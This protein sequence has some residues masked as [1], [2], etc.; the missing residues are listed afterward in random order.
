M[1]VLHLI[2]S[3]FVGGPEKQ[4]LEHF[5]RFS[6]SASPR[7]VLASFREGRRPSEILEA[8]GRLG[9]AT[10]EL[11]SAFPLDPRA[12]VDLLRILQEDDVGL[13]CA[14][15]YKANVVGRLAS[16]VRRI[17]LVVFSRGWTGE[18]ARVR[19]YESVDR[20]FLRWADH[21]IAVSRA[22]G[23]ALLALGIP[24]ERI[25]TVPNCVEIPP[26]GPAAPGR[27]RRELGLGPNSALVV[28]AGRLSPEKSFSTLVQAARIVASQEPT[29]HFVVFGEGALR[30]GLEAEIAAAGLAGRFH[31]PGFRRGVAEILAEVDVFALTSLTEGLPNAVLEASAASRP[32][33]ATAVGGV[34]EVVVDGETGFLVPPLRPDLLADRILDLLR[35][36]DLAERMGRA[37]RERAG[38]RFSFEAQGEALQA[39]Y[40]RLG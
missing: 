38:R 39:I 24:E 25:S 11:R 15:G 7:L 28:S 8:A 19:F 35:D 4:I 3:N 13:L 10:R 17:P 20:F 30:A 23:E 27:L 16:R 34:P 12:L 9:V 14:H 26:A 40:S 1:T 29:A 31:L 21:V 22:Q 33:V 2:G 5:R 6:G 32:V 36:R 37:A 18:N